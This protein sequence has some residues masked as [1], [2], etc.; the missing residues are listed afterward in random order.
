MVHFIRAGELTHVTDRVVPVQDAPSASCGRGS[1][2]RCVLAARASLPWLR[3]MVG[4]GLQLK[5][6][7]LA[8]DLACPHSSSSSK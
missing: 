1:Y 7:R 5:A 8:A 2:Y 4:A 3:G 6:I